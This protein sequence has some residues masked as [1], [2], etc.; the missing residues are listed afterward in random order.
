MRTIIL[1]IDFYSLCVLTRT[2]LGLRT[3]WEAL[4]HLLGHVWR[5][6]LFGGGQSGMSGE[7]RGYI[8]HFLPL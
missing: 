5:A 3:P 8:G 6:L 7:K 4:N 1:K 2:E